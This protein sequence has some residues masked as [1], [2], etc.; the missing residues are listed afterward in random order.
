MQYTNY[1]HHE[2]HKGNQPIRVLEN[3]I[4]NWF[5]ETYPDFHE[6][7]DSEMEFNGLKGI[8]IIY[9]D[10]AIPEVPEIN[11][12]REIVFHETFL[13]YLW[14]LSYSLFVIFDEVVQKCNQKLTMYSFR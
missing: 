5:K 10:I 13:S 7:V 1:Y 9:G 2:L 11:E 14:T 6:E 3:R 12:A 4:F 8:N